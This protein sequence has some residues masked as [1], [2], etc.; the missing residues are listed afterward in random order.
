MFASLLL[1]VTHV[2]GEERARPLQY[3]TLPYIKL[4]HVLKE[5]RAR[6]LYYITLHYI[7]ARSQGG[8]RA[9]ITSN[10][11]TLHYITLHYIT[12]THVLEEE[13]ARPSRAQHA[14]DLPEER[15]ARV[16]ERA[17]RAAPREG[18]WG[19]GNGGVSSA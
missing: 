14:H 9:A 5:E 19:A 4:T 17:A 6:P 18:L 7:D 15:A 1:S 13:R 2:L 3:I 12:L 16:G 11:I 10:C 8:T